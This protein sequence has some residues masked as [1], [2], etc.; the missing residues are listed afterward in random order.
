MTE[1]S[2]SEIYSMQRPYIELEYKEGSFEANLL[3]E[4]QLTNKLLARIAERLSWISGER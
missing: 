3:T 4:L 1:I 2:D